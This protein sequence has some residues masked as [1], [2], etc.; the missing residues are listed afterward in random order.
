MI[1][2]TT[3]D[4]T[5]IEPRLKHPTIFKY[6]DNLSYG[7]HFTIHNDHDPRPLYYQLLGERGNTFTWE[8]VQNGPEE[9]KVKITSYKEDTVGEIAASDLRKADV[10][11]A[12]G[13]DF[14]CGGGKTVKQVCAEQGIPEDKLRAA[15]EESNYT[16]T[17]PSRD[18]NKWEPAFLADY[19]I[20]TH[21]SYVKEQSPQ[22][23]ELAATVAA[24]HQEQHPELKELY[25][26]LD[27]LLTELADHLKKEEEI[28]FPM[29]RQNLAEAEIIRKLE[30]EHE[31][32]GQLLK[33][34]RQVT[35]N[36]TPPPSACN[37]Y[38]YLFK[39]VEEF[40]ED[41]HL[42]IHLENNILFKKCK[43]M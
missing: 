5:L 34:I 28:L 30:G 9:W 42:H 11:K 19:I 20:H 17:S 6:F 1:N 27:Q 23:R 31:T 37:S 41:L 16:S 22:L 26:L 14:C 2:G 8:Y 24:R 4:V 13:I 25:S 3:L 18:Y 15:L 43:L 10:F 35:N 32:A 29:I 21:H 40:E 33:Q 12:M 38:C 39:K 36:Y 7:E